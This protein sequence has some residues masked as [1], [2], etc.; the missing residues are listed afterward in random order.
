MAIT[1]YRVLE[2]DNLPKLEAAVT[3]A[4]GEGEQ[5]LGAPFITRTSGFA[6]A[7]V[8]EEEAP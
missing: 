5:P 6:Q 3:T 8:I 2:A 7:M 1:A 4:I